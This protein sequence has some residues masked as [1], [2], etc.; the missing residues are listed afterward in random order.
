M[1]ANLETLVQDG[2]LPGFNI[3]LSNRCWIKDPRNPYRIAFFYGPLV[4]IMFFSLVTMIAI[5]IWRRY[6]SPII[7]D[8]QKIVSK[9]SLYP[10]VLLICWT[11]ASVNRIQNAIDPSN[12]I[13][14]IIRSPNFVIVRIIHLGI[15]IQYTTRLLQCFSIRLCT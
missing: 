12:P 1:E 6:S 2:K 7:A 4:L 13:E 14:G 11:G 8:S 9:L 15:S 3:N 5:N 10:L